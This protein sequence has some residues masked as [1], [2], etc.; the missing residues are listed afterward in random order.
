MKSLIVDHNI[1][2]LC[3]CSSVHCVLLL[4]FVTPHTIF[5][6]EV[7]GH[8][9]RMVT[10]KFFLEEPGESVLELQSFVGLPHSLAPVDRLILW[11]PPTQP[12]EL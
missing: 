8:E 7:S 10:H 6:V 4:G 1:Q 9:S 5:E 2:D 3:L 11:K 12:T